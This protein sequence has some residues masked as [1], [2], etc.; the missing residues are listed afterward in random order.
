MYT[1]ILNDHHKD[2]FAKLR[3]LHQ[4]ETA[5]SAELHAE[6][7]SST[8]ARLAGLISVHLAAEDKFLYPN[9]AKSEDETV[10][11]TAQRFEQEMGG[12]ASAFKSFADSYNT[13]G[14]IKKDVH[15][16]LVA[17]KQTIGALESRLAKEEKEL[18]PLIRE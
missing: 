16:Y 13:A 18:Y 11:T 7:V 3:I 10:R 5:A 6:E 8:I 17:E 4:Y 12:L 1:E 2:I 14:K 9:L 15:A